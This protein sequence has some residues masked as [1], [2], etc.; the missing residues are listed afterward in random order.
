MMRGYE[1]WFV[2]TVAV[3]LGV[4]LIASAAVDWNWYY[5]L[6]SAR[7]LQRM[8]GRTGARLFHALLGLSLVVLGIAIALGHRLRLFG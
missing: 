6:R 8:L 2:G 3:L 4:F 5:S 7:L 1:D